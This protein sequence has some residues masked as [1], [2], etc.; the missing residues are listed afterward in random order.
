MLIRE[1]RPKFHDAL[2][3]DLTQIGDFKQNI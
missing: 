3:D 1:L 2:I